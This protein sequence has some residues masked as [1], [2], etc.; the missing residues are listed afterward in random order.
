MSSLEIIFIADIEPED[1]PFEIDIG[2]WIEL[3]DDK[4][5]WWISIYK[6]LKQL[7]PKYKIDTQ[8][9][10]FGRNLRFLFRSKNKVYN[11]LLSSL[12]TYGEVS[13]H[14]YDSVYA[15]KIKI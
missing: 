4:K 14:R 12:K 2:D 7:Y 5:L 9:G 8:Y 15:I 1:I 10:V 13:E 6:K 11:K 3:S